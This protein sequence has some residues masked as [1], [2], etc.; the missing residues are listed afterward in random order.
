MGMCVCMCVFVSMHVCAHVRITSTRAPSALRH[1]SRLTFPDEPLD[2][3]QLLVVGRAPSADSDE[4]R[5]VSSES[6]LSS[7]GTSESSQASA[8][9]PSSGRSVLKDW[10]GRVGEDNDIPIR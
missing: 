6:S 5:S 4:R 1:I 9:D 10:T 7:C 8:G 3:S 2:L